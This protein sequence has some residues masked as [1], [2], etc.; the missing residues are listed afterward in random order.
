M[1]TQL[2]IKNFILLKDLE[3]EFKNGLT[4]ITGESGS[5]KSLII[6]ALRCFLLKRFNGEFVINNNE[7]A[8]II[9]SFAVNN[10][11]IIN[12]ICAENFIEYDNDLILKRVISADGKSKNFINNEPVTVKLLNQISN[13]LLEIHG[14]F[15]NNDLFDDKNH[16]DYIDSLL[17]E[18]D[19]LQILAKYYQEYKEISNKYKNYKLKREEIKLAINELEDFIA[20]FKI[21]DLTAD[22]YESL[23][24]KNN[25]YKELSELK[26]VYLEIKNSFSATNSITDNLLSLQKFLLRN[27][28]KDDAKISLI[29]DKIEQ[30]LILSDEILSEINET[31]YDIDDKEQVVELLSSLKQ[32]SRKYQIP[33][34]NLYDELNK[35]KASL[36]KLK[37]EYDEFDNLSESL[38]AKYNL[39]ND[40]A[41]K[42]SAKRLKIIQHIEQIVMLNLRDLQM[43]DASFKIMIND[44]D[45]TEVN[46]KGNKSYNFYIKTN[47]DQP[48][49]KLQKIASGGELSR[50]MLALKIALKVKGKAMILDEIDTGISGKSAH[51]FALKLK[52]ISG[53]NQ[54][55]V[56]THQAQLAAVSDSHLKISKELSNNI[57]LSTAKILDQDEKVKEIANMISGKSIS[58][59]AI[60]AAKKL[61]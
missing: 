9:A 48:Y 22:Y 17:E 13:L 25:K 43:K 61:I 10:N 34:S 55:F 40:Y 33:A 21:F 31:E 15:D 47:I 39:F 38:S 6:D 18:P 4:V 52:E 49:E 58:T 30:Q 29:L 3:I 35:S 26:S 2:K 32:L 5:G 36:E 53:N 24:A 51:Y 44:L 50:F 16:I 23:I 7:A 28:E 54:V 45:K 27:K 56:I 41:N 1:L 14:Q 20:D 11:K 8:Q 59:E 46:K 42:I 12:S 37:K 57:T 60:E 19:D